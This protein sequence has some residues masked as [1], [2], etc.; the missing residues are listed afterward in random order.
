MGRELIKEKSRKIRYWY[1]C[2]GDLRPIGCTL[3]SYNIRRIKAKNTK[4]TN[5]AYAPQTPK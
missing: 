1:N 2:W 5:A 4:A 3:R